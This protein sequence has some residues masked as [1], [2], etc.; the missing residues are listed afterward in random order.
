[1]YDKNGY[2]IREGE[3]LLID[4]ERKPNP[5]SENKGIVGTYKGYDIQVVEIK[6]GD[7]ILLRLNDDV[8]LESANAIVEMM[9]NLYP[10]CTTIPVNEWFLK[11]MTILRNPDKE[12]DA[13]K[14]S[15]IDKPIEEMYP[16]LFNLGKGTAVRPGE[17]IW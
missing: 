13:V 8:D 1:M 10:E 15:I 9:N 3:I 16:D 7:T 6:P 4:N 12:C 5:F 11:G 17:I 14:L 2:T